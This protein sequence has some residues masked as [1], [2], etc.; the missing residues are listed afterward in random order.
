MKKI[1]LDSYQ[2]LNMFSKPLQPPSRQQIFIGRMLIVGGFVSNLFF[3]VWLLQPEFRGF[4]ILYWFIVAIF[5]FKSLVRM[6]EWWMCF[7]LSVPVKPPIISQWK[8]DVLTTYCAGEPKE[9]LVETLEAIQRISYP[10]QTFLCDEAD[11]TELKEVCKRLGVQHV[12]RAL[13][14]NAKAGN[15]NNALNTV[16]HGDICLILDPDHVPAPNFLDEVLSFFEDE[17]IG[18]VQVAQV[19]YNQQSTVIAKAAAQQTYQ[20]YGPFMMGLNTYGAVPAIGANCVFRRSALD[21]I[22]GHAPGLTEDMHTAMLLHSKGWKS[23]YHPVVVAKGLVPWNY[24]GYFIQQLKWSRGSFGL[25][26]TVLPKI[27]TKLSWK[28]LLYYLSAPIFYLAG[29]VSFLDFMIPILALIT[30]WV[31]VKV[32]IVSFV[33]FFLPVFITSFLIRQYFQRWLMDKH[34]SG[35]FLLGGT[36]FKASWLASFLGLFYSL[37]RKKVPYIP[38]PKDNRPESPW[39]LLVPNFII[40]ATSI[41]AI[42]YGLQRDYNPYMLFMAGLA[43]VNV[44]VLSLGNFMAMQHFIIKVHQVF[45]DSFITKHSKTRIFIYGLKHRMYLGFQSWAVP[46]LLLLLGAVVWFYQLQESKIDKLL[47][48]VHE[49]DNFF[50]PSMQGG[51]IGQTLANDQFVV[52]TFLLNSVSLAE[53]S[54][55]QLNCKNRGLIPFFQISLSSEHLTDTFQWNRTIVKEWFELLREKYQPVIIGVLIPD[56]EHSHKSVLISYIMSRIVEIANAVNYPNIAWVG[57]VRTSADFEAYKS[58]R[59]FI[60]WYMID[61][62]SLAEN[63]L[64]HMQRKNIGIFVSSK[65]RISTWNPEKN[66]TSGLLIN[67]PEPLQYRNRSRPPISVLGGEVRGVAYNPG[68][69][70]RD[71]SANLPLNREKLENDFRCIRSMGANTIRRYSSS[72]YDRNIIS[73]A[74][75]NNLKVMYGFWFDPKVDYWT[76]KSK[77][78]KY[79]EI[80]IENIRKYG[81]S[82][83]IIGWSL[84]NESWGLLKHSFNEPYLSLVRFAYINML[85]EIATEIR[86]IDLKTPIFVMEEHT[87]HLSSFVYAL[88]RFASEV[89]YVGVNS[90]YKKN[91]S[92][93]DSVMNS[94]LPG[95]KYLV[96]EFGPEGYWFPELNKYELDTL[97]YEPSSHQKADWMK[98]QWIHFVKP[99]NNNNSL[100][101]F[102]FCWQDRFEGTATWF[103]LTDLYGNRRPSWYAMKECFSENTKNLLSSPIPRF[104]ILMPKD[105]MLSGSTAVVRMATLST[106][107]RDQLWYRWV[108]YEEKTFREIY[109]SEKLKGA[110]EYTIPVP[111]KQSKYRLYAY[112]Y[113]SDGNVVSESSTMLIK[114]KK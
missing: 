79:K 68:H 38:T 45:Q 92:T 9:M 44:L 63:A 67:V 14:I 17:N 57:S 48:D 31:P 12:T 64:K 55:F 58:S 82:P 15:V 51:G 30:G 69:D 74:A 18:F 83:N 114:W 85:G 26:F 86:K 23:V 93:L 32:S 88:N 61:S 37:I 54:D 113:D 94:V 59:Y 73:I 41:W 70:W 76:D 52:D 53:L 43:A 35:A 16:A 96:S 7:S 84:G 77:V 98:Y 40:V 99:G 66:A 105:L 22:G 89:D 109:R 29:L 56:S 25:L 36:L 5:L 71:N 95:R 10:H 8:V 90:Y 13:K 49:Q 33:F 60:S 11:D 65:G 4:E 42:V 39:L 81:N 91:I 75:D 72:I 3:L 87:A 80:V 112:V 108:V 6:F 62:I 101:G 102:A 27:A 50:I 103:G 2:K 97:L 19:Y 20:F 78:N 1:Y 106:G 34:E 104:K 110:Y 111:K 100:G 24:S 47:I 28:Q 46:V 107:I 21:S